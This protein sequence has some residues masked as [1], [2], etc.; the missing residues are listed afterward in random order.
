VGRGWTAD[1]KRCYLGLTTGVTSASLLAAPATWTP[2][3]FATLD[4]SVA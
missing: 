4:V 1:P 3:D 2:A